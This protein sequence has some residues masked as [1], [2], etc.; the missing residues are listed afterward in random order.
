MLQGSPLK[1]LTLV[2]IL[3]LPF[4][5]CAAP[6]KE[7]A[8][9]VVPSLAA[10]VRPG[11]LEL[12]RWQGPVERVVAEPSGVAVGPL[13]E[14][15]AHYLFVSSDRLQDLQLFVRTY[16]PFLVSSPRGEMAFGGRGTSKA[17]AAEQRM[18][19]EWARQAAAEV[20]AGR[21]GAVYGMVFAW[22]RGGAVGN[23]DD[24]SVFLNGEVR[25]GSC[26]WGEGAEVRGR[27]AP[28]QL[29]RL[30]AWFDGLAPFQEG[31]EEGTGQIREPSRLVFAGQ[32]QKEAAP[33]EIAALRAFA[34]ALFRELAARRPGATAQAAAPAPDAAA[35][36]DEPDTA[37]METQTAKTDLTVAVPSGRLLLPVET[38]AAGPARA[39]IPE[40]LEPPALTPAPL[41]A[42]PAHPRERGDKQKKGAGANDESGQGEASPGAAESPPPL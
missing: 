4:A 9:A 17:G 28:E 40:D 27:L 38:A 7:P 19:L 1:K 3:L 35:E 15:L 20:T 13:G 14:P 8:P 42:P 36:Q 16:A 10:G 34:P 24:L 39:A 2:L 25:A 22:H 41:P 32:G 23:C 30:Y 12:R 18:I 26:S 11:T 5:G 6:A 31:S 37:D 21:G 29:P 33:E